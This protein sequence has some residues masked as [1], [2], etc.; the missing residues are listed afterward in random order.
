MGVRPSGE[1]TASPAAAWSS[2][3]ALRGGCRC[4]GKIDDVGGAR[5]AE[6]GE[7]RAL[8]LRARKERLPGGEV[9]APM[10][11]ARRDRGEPGLADPREELVPVEQL[12]AV[13][14][15]GEL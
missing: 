13:D 15:G 5:R 7:D 10:D 6:V 12:E 3:L 9:L 8:V 4:A 1:R 2:R 14:G 11:V